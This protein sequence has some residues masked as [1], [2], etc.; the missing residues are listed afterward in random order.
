[1]GNTAVSKQARRA[2]REAAA[3]A[4]EEVI[5]R[6]RANVEDL[7]A[8]FDARDRADAVVGWLA[9]RQQ[10]LREQAAQRRL[11]HRVQC[12]TAL[13]AMRD[14]GE[15]VREIARMAGISEKAV[16]DVI[17]ETDASE[18]LAE[19]VEAAAARVGT[20]PPATLQRFAGNAA[21]PVVGDVGGRVG[22][23]VSTP[24]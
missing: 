16:R 24:A 7:A 6:T 3:A 23:P 2:A 21:G 1:M 19:P 11:A 12:G 9:E 14:R 20:G 5:R 17:R 8:F 4:Q 15:T 13:R 10:A 22:E 18:G